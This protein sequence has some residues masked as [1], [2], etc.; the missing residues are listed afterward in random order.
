MTARILIKD[1]DDPIDRGIRKL[2]IYLQVID[3]TITLSRRQRGRGQRLLRQQL[4]ENGWLAIW[5]HD[6]VLRYLNLLFR[7]IL[8]LIHEVLEHARE[9]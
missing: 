7:L 2:L 9:I 5:A 6:H 8:S 3:I 1:C 4:V